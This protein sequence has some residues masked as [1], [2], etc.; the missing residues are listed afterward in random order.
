MRIVFMGTPDFAVPCLRELVKKDYNVVAVFTQPDRPKGRGKKILQTSVKEEAKKHNIEI[1]QPN[2][3]NNAE[4]LTVLAEIKPDLIIVVAYGQI[5]SKAILDIPVLGCINVH[6]SLLPKYRGAAPI[7]W[8][9]INGETS[10]GITTMYMDIGLDT[11]DMLLKDIIDIDESITAGELHDELSVLGAETLIKTI[12]LV[13][14]GGIDR[15]KQDNSMSCYAPML[16]KKLGLIDWTKPAKEIHNLVRG[17][18]PWPVAHTTYKG[19][20]MKVKKTS[21][22]SSEVMALSLPGQIA[23]V[24]KEAIYVTTGYGLL[25]IEELQFSGSKSLSAKSYL[26]GNKIDENTILGT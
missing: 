13:E 7:N 3:L 11:G 5:L 17:I 4:T 22:E 23:K 15:V 1:F 20:V 21:V 9:I 16:D 14:K 18:N 25:I 6:A 2:R 10:T 8:A 24:T 12:R 26:L 19:K